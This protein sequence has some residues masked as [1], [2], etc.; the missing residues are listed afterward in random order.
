MTTQA[1]EALV[2]TLLPRWRAGERLPALAREAAATLKRPVPIGTLRFW[3]VKQVGGAA[4]YA[5]EAAAREQEHPR[6]RLAPP[7]RENGVVVDDS[8]VPRVAEMRLED[9]WALASVDIGH[10]RHD[11]FV[12]PEGARYIRALGSEAADLI[13][14]P[15]RHG[16][17]PVRLKLLEGSALGRRAR[18]HA[19]LIKH[20]EKVRN[21]RFKQ[22]AD[23]TIDPHA[24]PHD[25]LR[26]LKRQ[27]V[28][29]KR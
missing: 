12:S 18:R 24:E 23:G 17:D 28:K 6:P 21:D 5:A 11:V 9:G 20:G 15:K 27:G 8:K 29:R 4:A 2:A 13:G 25:S 26:R 10:V 7:R 14:V 3:I 16:L 22:N 1:H 19:K